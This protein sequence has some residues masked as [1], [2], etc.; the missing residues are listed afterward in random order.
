MNVNHAIT[1][2]EVRVIGEDGVMLGILPRDV[3]FELSDQENLDLVE[4]SPEAHPP[5]CRLMNYGKYKYQQD[6]NFRDAKK[7]HPVSQIKEIRLRPQTD[8]HD[9]STK[10]VQA[11]K[12]IEMGHKVKAT[13]LFR[14]REVTHADIGMA[15]IERFSQELE[16]VAIVESMPHLDGKSLIMV[17][18]Q[19]PT[20]THRQVLSANN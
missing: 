6:K 4:V 9:L 8:S 3:A 16:D 2:A 5:V 18:A 20:K 10:L 11:R 14:G 1:A 13:M 19:K 12:F 17:L 7:H 15:A